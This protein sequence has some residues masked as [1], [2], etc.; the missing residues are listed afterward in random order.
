[1]LFVCCVQSVEDARATHQ[2]A[3]DQVAQQIEELRQ[4][5]FSV[6]PQ[7]LNKWGW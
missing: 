7:Q 1:V 6:R 4:T 3:A 2:A 5:A